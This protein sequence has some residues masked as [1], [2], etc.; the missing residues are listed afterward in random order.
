MRQA[1]PASAKPALRGNGHDKSRANG[2]AL[3]LTSGGAD[4][5]DAEFERM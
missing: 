2:F 5:H 1:R 4:P 3:K